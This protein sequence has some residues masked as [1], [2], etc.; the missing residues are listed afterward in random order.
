M[1]RIPSLLIVLLFA[2][3]CMAQNATSTDPSDIGDD[4]LYNYAQ[5]HNQ[6]QDYQAY[7]SL[8]PKG[9]HANAARK[10]LGNEYYRI[11]NEFYQKREF[12]AAKMWYMDYLK[13]FPNG[14]YKP[15]I[16]QKMADAD[17]KLRQPKSSFIMYSYDTNRPIGGSLG[18]LSR[19]KP[20]FYLSVQGNSE[21]YKSYSDVEYKIN[22]EG[23]S[24]Y[25][26]YDVVRTG[27]T[28]I[29]DFCFSVG[30][31]YSLSNSFWIYGGLGA[32]AKSQYDEV[33]LYSGDNLKDTWLMENTDESY[34]NIYPEAGLIF[35]AH[36]LLII[37][38]GFMYSKK[39]TQQI[40]V[41]LFFG[42]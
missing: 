20:G 33:N 19:I 25:D 3:N 18:T 16:V 11:G 39:L 17:I 23:T 5:N 37:R 27:T 10:W 4:D 29:S 7:L 12:D 26:V 36:K 2:M 32:N 24:D 8:Y 28:E 21:G 40:G 1:Y 15:D 22:N 31:T 30:I 41:G 42:R 35:K 6:M 9:K 34:T 14:T 38:Y 13:L